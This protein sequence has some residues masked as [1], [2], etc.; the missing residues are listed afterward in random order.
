MI[1]WS[2]RETFACLI[3]A[4]ILLAILRGSGFTL[5][6]GGVAAEL[7]AINKAV[8]NRPKGAPSVSDDITTLVENMED[9]INR[10]A[11]VE[12]LSEKTAARVGALEHPEEA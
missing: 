2:E 8:N 7:R 5:R 12:L 9:V 3:G 6:A 10:L 4:V 1:A 11:T